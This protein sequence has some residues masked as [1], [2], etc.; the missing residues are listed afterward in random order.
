MTCLAEGE[1]IAHFSAPSAPK[2]GRPGWISAVASKT[3]PLKLMQDNCSRPGKSSA[4][5]A[6]H[7]F[8][9]LFPEQQSLPISAVPFRRCFGSEQPRQTIFVNRHL[10]PSQ[11]EIHVD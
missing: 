2:T 11:K 4:R 3:S 8:L 10:N 5:G 9:I 6:S 1:S 7:P